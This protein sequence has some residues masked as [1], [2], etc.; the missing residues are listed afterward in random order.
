[1]SAREQ[2]MI[3]EEAIAWLIRT[4]DPDFGDWEGFTAWLEQG[5]AHGRA[6][7]ALC[8]ADEQLA[9]QLAHS[10]ELEAP[11]LPVPAN[12]IAPRRRWWLA[13]GMPGWSRGRPSSPS[14]TTRLAHSR[15]PAATM[16]SAI[17]AR[18]SM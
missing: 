11:D 6:Y 16:S 4:R 13:S 1:M 18:S 2:G 15:L 14:S 9:G 5:E 17:S 10:G 3:E 12:D 7:D 8:L